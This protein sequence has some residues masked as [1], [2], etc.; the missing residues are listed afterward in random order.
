MPSTPAETP[1]EP[2]AEAA[3]AEPEGPKTL[4]LEEF[5][6]L[7]ATTSIKVEASKIRHANEGTDQ[8]Q[9]GSV[10]QIKPADTPA[11][12]QAADETEVSIAHLLATLYVAHPYSILGPPQDPA[13]RY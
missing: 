10:I 4:T 11:Q 7:K 13:K 12:A 1:A 5:K 3:P 6:R 2:A 8:S 9:W